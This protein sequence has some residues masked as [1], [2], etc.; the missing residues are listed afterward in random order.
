MKKIIRE[1]KS[2]KFRLVFFIEDLATINRDDERS[3][4]KQPVFF[5]LYFDGNAW[6]PFSFSDD[7]CSFE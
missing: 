4:T 2:D 5:F 1:V 3:L 7:T 6:D